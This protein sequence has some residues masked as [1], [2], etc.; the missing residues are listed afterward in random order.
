MRHLF[1]ALMIAALPATALAGPDDFSTG[2]VIAEFGPS[3]TVDGA[4]PIPDDMRFHIAFDTAKD[5]DDLNRTLVSAARFLNM[6]ARAGVDPDR[7]A[8]AVVVHGGAIFD[9]LNAD[10]HADR[11]SGAANPNAELIAALREHKVRIIVCGQTAVHYDVTPSDL[12]PGVEMAV[13]AMTAHAQLQQ[14]DYTLNPF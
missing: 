11:K 4:M 2:P 14:D 3:A 10:T 5:G 12:L 7:V 9:V 6:Q 8:L 13:S 1:F